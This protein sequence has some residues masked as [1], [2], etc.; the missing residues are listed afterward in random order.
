[1][2]LEPGQLSTLTEMGIPVWERRTL[3]ISI[4]EI[5]PVS[6]EFHEPIPIPAVD[7]LIVLA[8]QDNVDET[9]RLLHAMLYSIGLTSN[10]SAIIFPH[11]LSQLITSVY[12][13]KLLLVLGDDLVPQDLISETMIRGHVY[14]AENSALK[15]ISSLSL[16]TLLKSPDQKALAWQDLQ[17]VKQTYQLDGIS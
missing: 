15:I 14:S 3:E 16:M 5:E 11:Q 8:E 13:H 2:M 12:E 9:I 4:A 1:M 7:C 10:N 17:L 6:A